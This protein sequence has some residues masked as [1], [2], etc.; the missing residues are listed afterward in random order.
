MTSPTWPFSWPSPDSWG[1]EID[2]AAAIIAASPRRAAA[3]WR[4]FPLHRLEV[5]KVVGRVLLRDIRAPSWEANVVIGGNVRDLGW[6]SS[7]DEGKAAV[8]QVIA[9]L[10]GET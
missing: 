4:T 3:P 10:A 5:G 8:E 2:E 6:F 7:A 9:E 1:T